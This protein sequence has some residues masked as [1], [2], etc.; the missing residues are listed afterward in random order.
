MASKR[1]TGSDPIASAGAS[2]ARSKSKIARKH[3]IAAV[4]TSDTPRVPAEA[5]PSMEAGIPVTKPA[6]EEIARLA[7][8]Y[9]E[10]RGFEGGSP[11]EDWLRA[12]RELQSAQLTSV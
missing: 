4:E 6:F 11:E 3:N 9:W 2:P 7:Y 1:D 8:S 5:S 12:E 10:K